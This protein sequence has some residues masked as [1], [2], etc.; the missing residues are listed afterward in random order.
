MI[1]HLDQLQHNGGKL[2]MFTMA[3]PLLHLNVQ[4]QVAILSLVAL[5]LAALFNKIPGVSELHPLIFH[6]RRCTQTTFWSP[7][8]AP[9]EA[10]ICACINAGF[11]NVGRPSPLLSSSA[12]NPLH[13]RVYGR[14]CQGILSIPR[15]T[16]MPGGTRRPAG[17]L[18]C[19]VAPNSLQN[20]PY[21]SFV[22]TQPQ[23]LNCPYICP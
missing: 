11:T 6:N 2:C 4:F 3:Q 12:K 15:M 23:L 16:R 1:S 7:F 20:A 17:F 10:M 8:S 9:K 5:F 18:L 13:P 22:H 21:G 19:P 14:N